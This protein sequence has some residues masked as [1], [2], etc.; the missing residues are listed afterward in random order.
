MIPYGRQSISA[1]D[2]AAVVAS[3]ESD[4]L[5]Q[6]PQVPAFE[7]A[8]CAYTGAAHAV[9]VNSATS[10][11]HIAYL[12]LGLG[13]GDEL[14]TS[15]VTFVAT[16]NA[17]LYCGATVRFIDIDPETYV[18]S[19]DALEARL[20]ETQAAGARLPKIVAP[21]HLSGQSCDMVRLAG[22]AARFGFRVVED[23]S[24]SI[25]AS[26]GDVPVG[27]CGQ[28]DICV[29][30]FHPV[31][32]ITTAEGGVA[33]TQDATLAERMALFRTHGITRDPKTLSRSDE[34]GWYYEQVS[35]GF[36]YRMTEMQAALGAS[37]MTRLD[38]FV[39]TRHDRA[40]AYD[41]ALAGLPLRLPR[42]APGQRSALHLYPILVT[43]EA[44]LGRRA[45]YDGLRAAGLGVNVHY[46]PIYRQ[47]YYQ[48]LGLPQDDCPVA[49]DYYARAISIPLYAGLSESDQAYVVDQLHRLLIDGRDATP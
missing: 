19:L 32:I 36:N 45:L 27:R 28:S 6:G 29:F 22:L 26:F 39:Q 43:D 4:F 23:A 24:H 3:L 40:R 30:S 5:T 42:Q 9:A 15:P 1:E 48:Q 33:T 10:A 13:P 44:P 41:A 35:L 47:P 2:V 16:A 8:I 49:E 34:G 17:A 21:V 11:L 14:W 18:L 25:G 38:Q 12:A 37:Q 7:A 20:L 31:K 46:I